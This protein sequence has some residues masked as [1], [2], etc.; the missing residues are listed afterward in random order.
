VTE[1][2][3]RERQAGRTTVQLRLTIA[4]QS[5]DGDTAIDWVVFSSNNSTVVG[6]RPQLMLWYAP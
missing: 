2:V 6:Q 5:Y 4:P 3:L 1:A